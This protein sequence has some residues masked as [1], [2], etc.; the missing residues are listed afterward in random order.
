M[1]RGQ[2]SLITNDRG[3]IIDDTVL[4]RYEDHV[5]TG[6]ESLGFLKCCP[7]GLHGALPTTGQNFLVARLE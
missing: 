5:T 1:H 3:G 2:L 6:F 4:S 7:L